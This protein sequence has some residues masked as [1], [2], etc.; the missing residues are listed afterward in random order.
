MKFKILFYSFVF[1]CLLL[2]YQVYNTNKILNYQETKIQNLY[3]NQETLKD[4]IDILNN[5]NNN[6]NYFSIER[7]KNIGLDFSEKKRLKNKIEEKLYDMNIRGGLDNFIKLPSGKFLIEN[8]HV[9]NKNWVLIGFRSNKY[10]GESLLEVKLKKNKIYGF[11][12]LKSFVN[13]L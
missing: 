7:N 3:L 10:W 13:P 12:S 1:V 6:F 2:F 4:S 8:V 11:I 5:F 9:I